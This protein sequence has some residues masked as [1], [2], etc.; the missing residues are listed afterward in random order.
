MAAKSGNINVMLRFFL[1]F[2]LLSFSAC[3][4]FEKNKINNL[5]EQR[6]ASISQKDITAYTSLLSQTYLENAGLKAIQ[7]MQH[8]F[9]TFEKIEMTSRDRIIQITD[10]N[11]AICEQTYVLNVFADDEWRK[12]VKREQLKFVRED[13]IWKISSGL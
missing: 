4:D 1:L 11:H 10:K 6:N 3:T 7:S 8:I 13:K 5:L 9:V 2:M 12:M